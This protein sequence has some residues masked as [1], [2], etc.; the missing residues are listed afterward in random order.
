MQVVLYTKEGC[1]LCDEVKAELAAL[2]ADYPHTLTEIDIT[3]QPGLF[4]KYR[5]TIPVV[6]IG[7]VELQAPITRQQLIDALQ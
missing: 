5:Y 7:D 3:T 2:A 6:H 4:Q 1:G